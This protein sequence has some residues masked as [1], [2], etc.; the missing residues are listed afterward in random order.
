MSVQHTFLTEVI[1][2][3]VRG[4]DCKFTEI[5]F[6]KKYSLKHGTRNI[7]GFA[8]RAGVSCSAVA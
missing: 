7:T 3:I 1:N 4:Q 2:L 5:G 8:V 6:P